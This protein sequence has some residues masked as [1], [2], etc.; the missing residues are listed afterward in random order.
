M[1]LVFAPVH[2]PVEALRGDSGPAKYPHGLPVHEVNMRLRATVLSSPPQE[3]GGEQQSAAG[4]GAERRQAM[5][6]LG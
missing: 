5:S 1:R 6:V 4:D 2:R 3:G